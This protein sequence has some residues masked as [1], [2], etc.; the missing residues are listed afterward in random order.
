[1]LYTQGTV[2]CSPAEVDFDPNRIELLKKHFQSLV[3]DNEIFCATYCLSRRGKVFAHGGVGYKSYQKDPTQLVSPTD[4]HYIA[5]VTKT[6][7][8]IAI[9]KLVEDGVIRLDTTVGEILPQFD[10]PPF[11]SITLF[12]LL[13][14]TSGM[15]SDGGCFPNKHNDGSYWHFIETA[16]GAYLNDKTSDKGEFDWIAAA[17]AY[18]VQKEPDKEW[19]YCSFGFIIIG[20]I[21]TKL[22]GMH[23][24]KY[25][26][27]HICKPLGLNDTGFDITPEMAKRYILCDDRATKMVENALNGKSN[28]DENSELWNKI[29]STGGGMVSTV[30]DMV[31][32]GNMV[33]HGGTFDGVRIMGRKAVEK[34]TKIQISKPDF[35]WGGNGGIRNYGIGI[36]HRNGP[37]FTFSDSTY[38]HEGAGACALYIDP[39]EEL[40]A[41]WI[42]P[43]VDRSK[44]CTKAMYN[45]VNVIWSGL[46]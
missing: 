46:R 5:S 2:E 45:T 6:F 19:M 13:T 43:F 35:C 7:A 24:H 38:M 39:D 34:M 21:I 11:N 28:D 44:W 42:S 32:Y 26:E 30:A 33:L 40:V 16:Y 20:E 27:E 4:I 23:C 18:G 41:A 1:M 12:H 29:P 14:H 25:I 36:D 3:D 8:G 10:S 22:S 15:H 17:L 31:R 9:M 37:Q